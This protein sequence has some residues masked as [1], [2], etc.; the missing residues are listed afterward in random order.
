MNFFHLLCI[1]N[2]PDFVNS[3]DII[4][5]VEQGRGEAGDS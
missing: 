5:N 1:D 2:L 4:M 3:Q